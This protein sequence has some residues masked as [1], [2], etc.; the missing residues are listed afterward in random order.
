MGCNC[1]K[2]NKAA[3]ERRKEQAAKREA[4]RQARL[5]ATATAPV[6]K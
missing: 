2:K 4:I 1:G 3:A 6:K 5:Q